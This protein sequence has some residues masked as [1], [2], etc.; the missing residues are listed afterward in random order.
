MNYQVPSADSKTV[1]LLGNLVTFRGRGA[2]TNN[3][4]SLVDVLTAPGAGTPP[5]LQKNDDEAFY[6]LDGTYEFM[7]D[8]KIIS[9]LPGTFVFVPRG[10]A[11]AFRN[12]GD[13]PARML[14]INTPGGLHEG[15]FDE[16]GDPVANATSFPA[17]AAPDMARLGA[18]ATRFGIE[19]LPPAK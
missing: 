13:K 10:A 18:A 9:G 6:V 7:L 8:G 15:F 19:F 11:H 14:I 12:V 3:Q 17:P 5:H 4:F 16:A 2:D 1:H